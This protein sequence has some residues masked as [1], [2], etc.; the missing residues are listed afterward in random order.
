VTGFVRSVLSATE[1]PC[2]PAVA[3]TA[4]TP[5]ENVHNNRVMAA[6]LAEL[7]LDVSFDEASDMHNFTAWRDVLDPCL[8]DL[9]HR[10]WS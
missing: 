10:V 8:T 2:R 6:H 1:S 3:M 9:L 5:E 7:G 4:G